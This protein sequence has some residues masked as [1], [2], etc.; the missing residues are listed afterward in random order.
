[1]E[2]TLLRPKRNDKSVLLNLRVQILEKVDMAVREQG[3]TRSQFFAAGDRAQFAP[4]F[5][6]R[7]RHL[8][9]HLSGGHALGRVGDVARPARFNVRRHLPPLDSLH[10]ET[11]PTSGN[12]GRE[13]RPH[14]KREHHH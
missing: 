1:M 8:R 11:V 6:S 5:T 4:L 14:A 12:S 7:T 2:E 13:H 3:V 9:S 10:I